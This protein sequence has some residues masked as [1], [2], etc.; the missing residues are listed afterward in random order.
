MRLTLRTLLAYL[1]DLLG[2]EETRDIGSKVAESK[3]AAD[4]VERIRKVVRQRRLTFPGDADG[5]FG[6]RFIDPN[7]VAEYL[8]N[9]LPLEAVEKTER[10]ILDDDVRLAEVAASHQVLGLVLGE[11][12]AIPEGVRVR[13]RAAVSAEVAASL[14]SPTAAP[15]ATRQSSG[16]FDIPTPPPAAAPGEGF[17][18]PTE[19]AKSDL[20]RF[21]PYAILG[22]VAVMWFG[23][24][25]FDQG[26]GGWLVPE[27]KQEGFEVAAVDDEPTEDEAGSALAGA[28]ATAG[29]EAVAGLEPEPAAPVE[30]PPDEPTPEPAAAEPEPPAIATTGPEAP[31]T[32][33]LAPPEPAAEPVVAAVAE[34][35]VEPA[36]AEPT[37][38]PEPVAADSVAV[39]G[40]ATGLLL[41]H[42]P[43]SFGWLPLVGGQAAEP[44]TEFAVP[45]PF[46]AELIC[47]GPAGPLAVAAPGG[48]R[49]DRFAGPVPSFALIRGRLAVS[50]AVPPETV[51][52]I[53]AGPAGDD[54]PPADPE[55]TKRVAF[56]IGEGPVAVT[57]ADAEACVAVEKLWPPVTV[58]DAAVA[59]TVFAVV[60]GSAEVT[61]AGGS[62]RT[63]GPGRAAVVGPTGLFVT[64]GAGGPAAEAAVAAAGDWAEEVA[65]VPAAPGLADDL[66]APLTADNPAEIA[67]PPLVSDRRQFLAVWAIRG[68]GLIG[69]VD[70]LVRAMTAPTHDVTISEAA[71]ELRLAVAAD[72]AAAGRLRD[73]LAAALPEEEAGFVYDLLVTL[74][75]ADLGPVPTAAVLDALESERELIRELAFEQFVTRTG[76]RFGYRPDMGT[77]RRLSSVR[78]MRDYVGRVGGLVAEA[79]Q[80]GTE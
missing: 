66:G 41:R 78:R 57:L 61:D 28:E 1:D 30:P 16:Q 69:A 65:A 43:E 8:D 11:P 80:E 20:K 4:L 64:P 62:V 33:D 13:A 15:S 2:P 7:L 23:L 29:E 12:V 77:T 55:A 76:R 67:L 58:R 25:W 63:L 47:F 72:P 68:L 38:E 21:A 46:A 14:E 24:I 45:E 27:E 19:S 6:D 10:R 31:L 5:G 56:A 3:I 59:T 36:P 17:G 51:E 74:T 73:A 71:T 44:V 42:R 32:V 60:A 34:P 35:V 22:A 26:V 18:G 48:T 49:F 53:A 9:T 79:N 37:P 39:S 54:L 50:A 75:A 40:P 70:P 52:A